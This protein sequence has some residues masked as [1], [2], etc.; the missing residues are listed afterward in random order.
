MLTIT[1]INYTP[2]PLAKYLIIVCVESFP[3]DHTMIYHH[4]GLTAD[5]LDHVSHGVVVEPHYNHLQVRMLF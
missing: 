3:P 4:G 2:H 5:W 1:S